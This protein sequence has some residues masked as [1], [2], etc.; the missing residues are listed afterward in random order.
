MSYLHPSQ[1]GSKTEQIGPSSHR[2]EYHVGV[3]EGNWFEERFS[4]G[5]QPQRTFKFDAKSNMKDCF[6]PRTCDEYR[7]AKPNEAS[8]Q[9]APRQL[10][11]G[12]G[13]HSVTSLL[14]VSELCYKDLSQ[15]GIALKTNDVINV[16]GISPRR[17]R[18]KQKRSENGRLAMDNSEGAARIAGKGSE[19]QFVTT[20][21]VTTDATGEYMLIHSDVF[22]RG[23][24]K[25]RGE[26]V[27]SMSSPMR[28]TGLREP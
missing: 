20:K 2:N 6:P 22:V 14:T 11:F 18:S 19:R 5:S 27:K 17:S 25:K 9:E 26:F 1:K 7:S 28:K 10:L 24:C 23:Q 15:G 21:N 3:L 13:S 16:Q 12:H 8:V 4:F